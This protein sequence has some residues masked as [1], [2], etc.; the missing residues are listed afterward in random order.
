MCNVDGEAIKDAATACQANPTAK[1]F[2]LGKGQAVWQDME[3]SFPNP[4]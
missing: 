1:L 3:P 2:C 4:D